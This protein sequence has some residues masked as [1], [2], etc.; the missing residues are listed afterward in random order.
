MESRYLRS[1][2]FE[3]FRALCAKKRVAERLL[4]EGGDAGSGVVTLIGTPPGGG[5][6]TGMHTHAYRQMLYIVHGV[7]SVEVDGEV[8]DAGPGSLVVFPA[9][10]KHRNWNRTTAEVVHLAINGDTF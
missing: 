3:S 7:M 4:D 5:S 8:F 9:G 1:I 6:P 2:D 10:V